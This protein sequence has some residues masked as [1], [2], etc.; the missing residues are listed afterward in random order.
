MGFAATMIFYHL[1]GLGVAIAVFLS[2]P[3]KRRAATG[4]PDGD[5]RGLLAVVPADPAGRTAA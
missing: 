4:L 5:R 1:I 3:E 2:E